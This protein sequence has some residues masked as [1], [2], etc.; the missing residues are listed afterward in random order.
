[1]ATFLFSKIALMELPPLTVVL[2]RV[3]F[4]AIALNLVMVAAGQRWPGDGAAWRAFLV[5][6]AINNL[7]PF[8]LIAWGQT[9]IASGLASILNATTPLFT[10]IV[11]H[12][13]TRDEKLT[14]NKL[15]GVLL[16]LAGVS[17]MIGADTI[18]G[19]SYGVAGQIACL[20]AALCYAFA[21]IYGRR[22]RRMGLSPLATAT[23]QVTATTLMLLPVVALIDRPWTFSGLPSTQT[24]TALLAAALLCTA[25][26]Y[27]LY[28][29]ILATAGATNLMLVTLVMPA[30]AILLG[31]IVLGERLA[32]RHFAGMTLIGIGLA[33]I[34]GRPRAWLGRYGRRSSGDPRASRADFSG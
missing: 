29:R 24:W 6:G 18:N 27:V 7:I 2:G 34:D 10:I 9:H 21:G 12:I 8:S 15:G 22:F 31:A 4:A 33:A 20:G 30:G 32:P 17:V 14:A 16:G 19:M 13:A 26:G 3:G 1:S 11:A 25:L 23:G 28:F 5:M